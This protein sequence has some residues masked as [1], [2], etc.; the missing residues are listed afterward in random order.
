MAMEQKS[1]SFQER[2]QY[3]LEKLNIEIAKKR[4]NSEYS[5]VFFSEHNTKQHIE[6]MQRDDTID[7]SNCLFL[8]KVDFNKIFDNPISY[9][10]FLDSSTERSV[11]T[12]V[13]RS[14]LKLDFTNAVFL[15]RV[16][17]NKLYFDKSIILNGTKFLKQV[18]FNG[19]CFKTNLS[20][21]NTSFY[22]IV[23]F[24]NCDF[25]GYF[26][27]STPKRIIFWDEVFF[28]NSTFVKE[29][30]FM[31]LIFS[32]NTS[33]NKSQFLD[34]ARFEKCIFGEKESIIDTWV[35]FQSAIFKGE[36]QFYN[37]RFYNDT[38]FSKSSFYRFTNFSN[39]FIRKHAAFFGTQFFQN[40]SF[41]NINKSSEKIP[42]GTINLK[43]CF[44][45]Q[46]LNFL[47]SDINISNRETARTIK[48]EFLK[49]NNQVEALKYHAIEMDL[50]K[51]E[52][53][54]L[55]KVRLS[56]IHKPRNTSEWLNGK[57][58][59][60]LLWFNEKITYFGL[61]P[62]L[63]VLRTLQ[64]GIVLFILYYLSLWSNQPFYFSTNTSGIETMNGIFAVIGYFLH[65]LNP[66]RSIDFIIEKEKLLGI[67]MIIDIISRL[68]MSLLYYQTIQAFRK[69][70]RKF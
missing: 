15:D 46:N 14:Y 57:S 60:F 52:S 68:I 39:C 51:K 32:K 53:S 65:F 2:R 47:N 58:D 59:R 55:P 8:F 42:I 22:D 64:V 54:K 1:K 5:A 21:G 50:Y 25:E 69:F 18:S 43:S 24:S 40:S 13:Y 56:L 19:A 23:Y 34:N 63:G 17:F 20:L 3:E 49:Q 11:Y 67:P 61:N 30:N 33:F 12:K 38:K 16:D 10:R 27:A 31:N 29:A 44:C 66:A 36:A 70:T 4:T 62:G 45:N 37:V 41:D 6:H 35:D 48:H 26:S 28:E 7:F 9:K